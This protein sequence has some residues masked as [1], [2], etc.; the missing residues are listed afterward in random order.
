[1]RAL[2]SATLAN[3]ETIP[4][5]FANQD[6]NRGGD[7]ATGKELFTSR[8][9][10]A[11][12]LA[13]DDGKGGSIGPSLVDVHTRFSAHYLAESIL[14]PNRFVSP[15]FHPT[16]LT[17]KDG[18]VHTGFIEKDE[19]S[20]ALRIITGG[21]TE[22]PA[23]EIAKRETSHQSMMPAGLVQSPKEMRHLLA[24]MLKRDSEVFAPLKAN[25]YRFAPQQARFVRVELLPGS[26]RQPCIDEIEIFGPGSDTNLA[27]AGKA[28]AS[29][30]LKGYAWKHQIHFLNDGKY[31]NAHSWIPAQPTGW[32]QIELA[33][34]A[35]LDRVVLSRD[36]GGKLRERVPYNFDI[37]LSADG[38]G[39]KTVKKV[40]AG[41]VVA[42]VSARKPGKPN[43]V[44]I[45]ADDFGWGDTSCNNP[46][47]PIKTPA[48]DRIAQEG[49]RLTN[50][51]TPSAV[52]TPTRY[53]LLT[54][55]YPWRSYL[56]SRV[57]PYYAP[58][59]ITKG[60]P[61][62]A[63]YLK[64]QGYRTGGFG[65][66]H[67]GLDWTPKDGDP[68]DWRSHSETR[69]RQVALRVQK[70]IDHSKPF[71]NAPTDIGFDTYFGTASN[72]SRLPFF[73]EDN[74]VVGKLQVRKDGWLH[75][76]DC[77]RTV[78][79]DIYVKRAIDFMA[80]SRDKPFFVYLPLNAIHGAVKAP[81]RHMG[82]SGMSHREDKIRWANESVA[83]I[84][85]AL[86]QMGLADD[87]LL[88][89]TSDNGPINSPVA[90][91]Q[92]H[93]PTGPYRG[94]KTNVYEGG[95]RVPFLARWPGRIRAGATGDQLIGL[96][97]VF[98]TVAA[99]CGK[100]PGP[101]AAPDSHSFL[102]LLL[103]QGDRIAARPPLVTASYEGFL[104]LYQGKWKAVFDTQWHGGHFGAAYGGP[105]PKDQPADGPDVGQLFD[106]ANDPYETRDL[107]DQKPEIV[108]QLRQALSA[109]KQG[110]FKR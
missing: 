43:I 26:K 66:W 8:G 87:T 16:T 45:L 81:S 83:K 69:D 17:M 51:H 91:K 53:G 82:K 5:E 103:Q 48:I 60:R 78:V 75:D 70:G 7:A 73:I 57:L 86:D 85:D 64:S 90:R 6:W 9:C 101:G 38:K 56:K 25:V 27:L 102:P 58:A 72:C 3:G 55:R 10:I 20:V 11:C 19:D 32:A 105:P 54:G 44:L 96:T 98:A 109:I 65:K 14:L 18:S 104:A 92:G 52:C 107:W 94:L 80:E 28:S 36:R 1:M 15:N 93:E 108:S 50:A 41:R 34:S 77:Q 4:A 12:H 40:R 47:S 67:L 59:L 23:A 21:L 29:S 63:S 37:K 22:L 99:V 79:D 84:L 95:T 88:I 62:I 110:K 33:E 61:T 100:A 76:P 68:S 71:Q 89:F 13:P 30:L 24:Y 97:D 74:R 35:T 46:D 31:T 2:K 42:A 39:W 106:I 49:I